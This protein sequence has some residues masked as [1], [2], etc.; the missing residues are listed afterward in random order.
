MK[1]FLLCALF[2]TSSLFFS[3]S[4]Q[5]KRT[6]EISVIRTACEASLQTANACI[7]TG[8][9]ENAGKTLEG[10]YTQAMSIDNAPLLVSV[11]L[12]RVSLMLSQ[13]PPDV[14]KAR[15][16]LSDAKNFAKF[17]SDSAKQAALCTMNE[18][19][20]SLEDTEFSDYEILTELLNEC[21]KPLKS[22]KYNEAH[23]FSV[24]G[25]LC[26]KQ[27]DYSKAEKY[28]SDAVK[29]YSD[30]RY[31]AEIGLTWYKIAQVRS[32]SGNNT[33]ALE[34]LD[35]AVNFDRASEN[36]RALGIDYYIKGIIYSRIDKLQ[37]AKYSFEH[38]ADI[39]DSIN[40]EDLANRSRNCAQKL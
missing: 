5:P 34:A 4:S 14:Q 31:L 12:A 39:F 23:L 6:M 11:S 29:K 15:N 17:C 35:N 13:N 20:I 38:S 37:E 30:N 32:L 18:V 8:D 24:R 40:L 36:T 3:C 22:D 27:K 25:D 33:G 7:L 1:T 28:F 21:E 19:R 2:L 26:R 16:Y 10:C 9:F